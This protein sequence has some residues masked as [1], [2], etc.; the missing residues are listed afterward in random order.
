MR[1][2]D[3]KEFVSRKR[4]RKCPGARRKPRSVLAAFYCASVSD[5]LPR[6]LVVPPGPPGSSRP[7]RSSFPAAVSFQ[8]GCQASR[9]PDLRP[10][11]L[12][13]GARTFLSDLRHRRRPTGSW[14][15]MDDLESRRS[16]RAGGHLRQDRKRK[17]DGPEGPSWTS[18]R[19]SGKPRTS[20]SRGRPAWSGPCSRRSREGPGCWPRRCGP[21]CPS[22]RSCR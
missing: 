5:L 19:A 10:A 21:R 8:C 11:A 13:C 7:R 12:R 2:W 17:V 6:G 22:P 4:E 20:Q 3:Y 14:T 9:P 18:F 1:G 16:P 15:R